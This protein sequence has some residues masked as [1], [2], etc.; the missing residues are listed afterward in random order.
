MKTSILSA[1]LLFSLVF[2]SP[3]SAG[4]NFKGKKQVESCPTVN[5]SPG[6]FSRGKSFEK[7]KRISIQ[8]H[9]L[10]KA[11]YDKRQKKEM[12][13]PKVRQLK[14]QYGTEGH[15]NFRKLFGAM[16]SP[17]NFLTLGLFH[18]KQKSK[19]IRVKF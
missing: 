3:L 11:S 18:R 9:K 12:N 19:N 7:E 13:S 17:D 15:G 14:N 1:T 16:R 4:N 5:A 6:N 2:L 10:P 8:Y